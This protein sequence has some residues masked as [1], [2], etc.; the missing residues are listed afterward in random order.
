MQSNQSKAV[1]R[2]LES[3]GLSIGVVVAPETQ[4]QH[5]IFGNVPLAIQ[6]AFQATE[7]IL[8]NISVVESRQGL[9]VML[10]VAQVGEHQV[11]VLLNLAD[12]TVKKMLLNI[13]VSGRMMLVL[14]VR[15]SNQH[16][17]L[18]NNHIVDLLPEITSL[19]DSAE[20]LRNL[21]TVQDMCEL[22]SRYHVPGAVPA[23]DGTFPKQMAVVSVFNV[24]EAEM[25]LS[26]SAEAIH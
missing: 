16:A 23:S 4:G 19:A 5:A 8:W 10:A 25:A 9:T 18:V 15:G 13:Q 1:Q 12:P 17:V 7:K 26:L 14:A 21:E 11:R 6:Q 24:N 20:T 3:M 22:A 2:Y